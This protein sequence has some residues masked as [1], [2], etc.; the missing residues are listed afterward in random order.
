MTNTH[1]MTVI[2]TART[3]GSGQSP[4]D[5]VHEHIQFFTT[6]GTLL[7]EECSYADDCRYT[8]PVHPEAKFE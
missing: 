5:A 3:V 7:A 4:D 1:T 6:D 2:R 8:K